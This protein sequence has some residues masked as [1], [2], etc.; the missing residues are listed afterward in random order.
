MN[1]NS[2]NMALITDSMLN[3]RG[4]TVVEYCLIMVIIAIAIIASLAGIGTN[5]NKAYSTV[6]SALSK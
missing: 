4:V 1:A 2:N 6:N 3:S 5:A